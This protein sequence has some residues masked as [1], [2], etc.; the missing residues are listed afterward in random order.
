MSDDLTEKELKN[1]INSFR[2]DIDDPNFDENINLKKDLNHDLILCELELYGL[3]YG[4]KTLGD[5]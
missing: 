2:K 5:W 1:L 4:E 3:K